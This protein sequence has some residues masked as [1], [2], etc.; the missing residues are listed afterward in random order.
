M[1]ELSSVFIPSQLS[2]RTNV[3]ATVSRL[4]RNMSY[5]KMKENQSVVS[6]CVHSSKLLAVFDSVERKLVLALGFRGSRIISNCQKVI[7][8]VHAISSFVVVVSVVKKSYVRSYI[9]CQ[10][11]LLQHLMSKD[12]EV[13]LLVESSETMVGAVVVAVVKS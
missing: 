7:C 9:L 11:C 8:Q 4:C 10:S 13:E 1:L 3:K 6:I 2:F 5:F 12:E